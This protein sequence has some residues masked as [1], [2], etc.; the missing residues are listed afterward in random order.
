MWENTSWDWAVLWP[1]SRVSS[2][3][4]L[5]RW[6]RLVA[7]VLDVQTATLLVPAAAVGIH[8]LRVLQVPPAASH[9]AFSSLHDNF[10]HGRP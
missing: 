7:P 3:K 2:A 5:V 9:F 8:L 6:F 1:Q 10:P 4:R